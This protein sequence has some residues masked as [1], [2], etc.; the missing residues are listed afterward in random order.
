MSRNPSRSSGKKP[1]KSAPEHDARPETPSEPDPATL[2]AQLAALQEF[3]RVV[4]EMRQSGSQLLNARAADILGDPATA[5]WS[6]FRRH[7]DDLRPLERLASAAPI[8]PDGRQDPVLIDQITRRN[9]WLSGLPRWDDFQKYVARERLSGP[10]AEVV[11][12][13]ESRLVSKLDRTPAKVGRLS[14]ADAVATLIR[15]VVSGANEERDRFIYDRYMAGNPLKA[16][17]TEV[18]SHSDWT[19]LGSADAVRKA[20]T[21]YC[22][23]HQID[24]PRRKRLRNRH[25]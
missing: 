17:M 3:E 4:D 14:F 23:L 19:E 10:L 20:M 6:L 5:E 13:L 12:E 8:A 25:D 22:K 21:R 24:I 2:A 1:A 7:V 9:V 15:P 18:N 11:I 16:I